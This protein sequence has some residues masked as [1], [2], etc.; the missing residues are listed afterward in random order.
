MLKLLLQFAGIELLEEAWGFL[1]VVGVFL[2]EGL[3]FEVYVTVLEG[4]EHF[5]QQGVELLVR[6]VLAD[7]WTILVVLSLPVDLAQLKE[8]IPLVKDCPKRIEV[9]HAV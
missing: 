1:G 5:A 3:G 8:G 7:P 2:P 6:G 4:L 9:F